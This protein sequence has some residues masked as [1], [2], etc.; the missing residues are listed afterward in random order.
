[1]CNQQGI[2]GASKNGAQLH[3]FRY[4]SLPNYVDILVSNI[5]F[6]KQNATRSYNN[7][8]EATLLLFLP[9]TKRVFISFIYF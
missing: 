8:I 6:T 7:G 5:D 1:M 4:L 3:S 2:N 9:F